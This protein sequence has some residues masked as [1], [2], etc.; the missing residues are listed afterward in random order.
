MK[1]D[2]LRSLAIG[3]AIVAFLAG[4]VAFVISYVKNGEINALPVGIG[5]VLLAAIMLATRTKRSINE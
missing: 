1:T 3:L 5:F 4:V 2:F